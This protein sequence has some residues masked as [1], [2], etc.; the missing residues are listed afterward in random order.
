MTWITVDEL[1][2][3]KDNHKIKHLD[4]VEKV[5]KDVRGLI[6][7]SLGE[8]EWVRMKM[9]EEWN[10]WVFAGDYSPPPD[11]TGGHQFHYSEFAVDK[12]VQPRKLAPVPLVSI[13]TGH[14]ELPRLRIDDRVLPDEFEEVSGRAYRLEIVNGQVKMQR[15]DA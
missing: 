6:C 14:K 12:D 3:D 15:W 13:E 7:N 10:K 9:M 4:D 1:M 11:S 2:H 5:K 8:V